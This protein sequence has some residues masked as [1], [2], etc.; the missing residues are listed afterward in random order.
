ML[1]RRET[2]HALGAV[3]VAAPLVSACGDGASS[4]EPAGGRDLQLVRADVARSAGDPAAVDGVVAAAGSLAVDLWGQLGTT[5]DNLALSPFSIAVA[6]AMTANGAT[7][8][9]SQQM[10]DVL[11]VDS[12]A[13]YNA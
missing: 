8:K 10:L 2:L 1:R 7:G 11:H 5:D 13:T 3:G 12:L 6:L 9:T 4:H